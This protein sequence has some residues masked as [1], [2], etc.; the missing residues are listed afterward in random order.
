MSA[1]AEDHLNDIASNV[2]AMITAG[3]AGHFS[4]LW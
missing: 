1:L 3:V 4:K 2:G